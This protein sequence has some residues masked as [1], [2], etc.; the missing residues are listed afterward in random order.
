M[1]ENQLQQLLRMVD[2]PML[3]P[4]SLEALKR[5]A[6]DRKSLLDEA[7]VAA[8]AATQGGAELPLQSQLENLDTLI[9]SLQGIKRKL[10]DVSQAEREEAGR[11]KAR[12]DHLQG[13]TE[14]KDNM[15]VW[16][17]QRMD[18]LLVDYLNRHVTPCGT[19]H[20]AM[21]HM[22]GSPGRMLA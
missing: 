16:N 5:A 10:Q 13:L 21:W 11:V 9:S 7:Q 8:Q 1:S 18:T 3:V 22:H 20:H 19:P 2:V 17:K 14:S 12:L 6:K 4:S 15:I